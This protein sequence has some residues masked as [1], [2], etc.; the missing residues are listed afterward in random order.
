LSEELL[1]SV[2]LRFS[3]YELENDC[4]YTY[5][6]TYSNLALGWKDVKDPPPKMMLT[7]G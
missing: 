1:P 5:P 2:S 6:L 3:A 4:T 7:S